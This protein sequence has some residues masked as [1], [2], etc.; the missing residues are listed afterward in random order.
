MRRMIAHRL[1]DSL[2]TDLPIA[3]SSQVIDLMNRGCVENIIDAIKQAEDRL[4]RE[5][6][7]VVIDTYAKGI[8][9]GG[10]D[11]SAAKDQNAALANLRRVID[12]ISV[13]I[14]TVG[15][16]GKDESRG[17]RG[18]NAKLADVDLQVQLSGDM[19]KTATVK[20]ANDQEQGP[21]TSFRLEP[22]DFGP[23]EDGDPF[24][25]FILSKEI[26]A[27]PLIS[28]RVLSGK[29]QLA[30]DALAEA[31]LSHGVNLPSGNGMPAGLKAVT[32][33]QWRDELYRRQ[34]LDRDAKNP[35][36]RFAELRTQLAGRR[37]IGVQDE[38]VW[39]TTNEGK[40]VRP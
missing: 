37:L 13:H 34:V 8:A 29:Q 20:K 17:E 5:I 3:V 30:I 16:T 35:R 7:L 40:R 12:K 28:G 4:G 19:T 1:R 21:L 11:E 6:G 32:A 14:A 18:S 15:H 39:L 9:A 24:R 22:Y 36:A 10:G 23:D 26:I 33:E 31:V 25:T 27:A 2:P 38:S